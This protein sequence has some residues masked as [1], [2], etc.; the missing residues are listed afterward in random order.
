MHKIIQTLFGLSLLILSSVEVLAVHHATIKNRGGNKIKMGYKNDRWTRHFNNGQQGRHGIE[1]GNRNYDCM[2]LDRER[3]GK[4]GIW[5]HGRDWKRVRRINRLEIL[6]YNGSHD[7]L[8]GYRVQIN[9]PAGK[10]CFDNDDDISCKHA[11]RIHGRQNSVDGQKIG[12]RYFYPLTPGNRQSRQR[13]RVIRWDGSGNVSIRQPHSGNRQTRIGHHRARY[14]NWISTADDLRIDKIMGIKYVL[15]YS[16]WRRKNIKYVLMPNK[17][18]LEIVLNNR[19]RVN[20]KWWDGYCI[21]RRCDRNRFQPLD[22]LSKEHDHSVLKPLVITTYNTNAKVE[23]QNHSGKDL[24]VG[25]RRG[26]MH[27]KDGNH[28]WKIK[29][30]QSRGGFAFNNNTHAIWINP[31]GRTKDGVWLSPK[32]WNDKN[33]SNKRKI[34]KVHIHNG[35]VNGVGYRV[36]LD[37]TGGKYCFREDND[38]N[39]SHV[40]HIHG[41]QPHVDGKPKI[42]DVRGNDQR[43]EFYRLTV[44]SAGG[45]L[46][47]INID[48]DDHVQ[49]NQPY[50]GR[51]GYKLKSRHATRVKFMGNGH[52]IGIHK[53]NGR[54]LLLKY[55]HWHNKNIKHI[56]TMPKSEKLEIITKNKFKLLHVDASKMWEGYCYGKY[57]DTNRFLPLHF[58]DSDR[59]K[60]DRV[61][62]NYHVIMAPSTAHKSV[63]IEPMDKKFKLKQHNLE[64]KELDDGTRNAERSNMVAVKFANAQDDIGIDYHNDGKDGYA[65]RY[66][67]WKDKGVYKIISYNRDRHEIFTKPFTDEMTGMEYRG[68]CVGKKCTN[69]NLVQAKIHPYSNM[70]IRGSKFQEIYPEPIYSGKMVIMENDSKWHPA[71]VGNKNDLKVEIPIYKHKALPFNEDK[72]TIWADLKGDRGF[73]GVYFLHREWSRLHEKLSPR[74]QRILGD[75]LSIRKIRFKGNPSKHNGSP[76]KVE[77][78]TDLGTFCLEHETKKESKCTHSVKVGGRE[79][80]VDGKKI[81]RKHFHKLS[82]Q[83]NLNL[84]DKILVDVGRQHDVRVEFIE[85]GKIEK[86]DKLK[87]GLVTSLNWNKDGDNGDYTGVSFRKGKDLGYVLRHGT[88]NTQTFT[89]PDFNAEGKYQFNDDGSLKTKQQ[90]GIRAK[91]I[92]AHELE[93]FEVHTD[94]FVHSKGGKQF[95]FKGFCIGTKCDRTKYASPKMDFERKKFS[96]SNKKSSKKYFE[97][98]PEVEKMYAGDA[99]RIVNKSAYQL[100]LGHKKDWEEHVHGWGIGA[101]VTTVVV[102]GLVVGTVVTGGALGVIAFKVGTAMALAAGGA[103]TVTALGTTGLVSLGAVATKGIVIAGIAAG[104]AGG[105]GALSATGLGA[106]MTSLR[107]NEK[108]FSFMH[109]SDALWLDRVGDRG[110]PAVYLHPRDWQLHKKDNLA[111]IFGS[112]GVRKLVVADNG[113]DGSPFNLQVET[114]VGIFCLNGDKDDICT[115]RLQVHGKK[116]NVDGVKKGRRKFKK[117][118]PADWTIRDKIL[119]EPISGDDVRVEQSHREIKKVIKNQRVAVNW[120]GNGDDLGV[121]FRRGGGKADDGY[122]LQHSFW[123][124]VRINVITTF[125]KNDKRRMVINTVPFMKDGK[126]WGG[127]CHGNSCDRNFYLSLNVQSERRKVKTSK[128]TYYKV[129]P[130][131]IPAKDKYLDVIKAAQSQEIEA[132][133]TK[134]NTAVGEIETVINSIAYSNVATS[135]RAEIRRLN[136]AKSSINGMES[137]QTLAEEAKRIADDT[138]MKKTNADAKLASIKEQIDQIKALSARAD[139]SKQAEVMAKATTLETNLGSLADEAAATALLASATQRVADE[140]GKLMADLTMQRGM[141]DTE[142]VKIRAA[143]GVMSDQT[144]TTRL[145]GEIT[146]LEE[147]KEALDSVEAVKNLVNNAKEIT[148]QATNYNSIAAKVIKITAEVEKIKA[149]AAVMALKVD[150]DRFMGEATR[151]LEAAKS[152]ELTTAQEMTRDAQAKAMNDEIQRIRQEIS[153]FRASQNNVTD[154][155]QRTEMISSI[156][157]IQ[158]GIGEIS[159][160]T[161]ATAKANQARDLANNAENYEATPED[162]PSP[163][164]TNGDSSSNT[165]ASSDSTL[166]EAIATKFTRVT[167]NC[168][169]NLTQIDG[170]FPHIMAAAEPKLRCGASTFT[171]HDKFKIPTSLMMMDRVNSVKVHR[172][173][174]NLTSLGDFLVLEIDEQDVKFMKTCENVQILQVGD[175]QYMVSGLC[176]IVDKTTGI[177]NIFRSR[178]S[179]FPQ[180]VSLDDLLR[181]RNVNG[182]LILNNNQ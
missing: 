11:I 152:T 124:D 166:S 75:K 167:A 146:R 73:A 140:E 60:I 106:L 105:V 128:K 108:T 33:R 46:R 154:R 120:T 68:F 24:L 170:T 159:T 80:K 132:E 164:E 16:D 172:N 169:G 113:K 155:A 162:T 165:P 182:Q 13:I 129:T 161:D 39:C 134:I 45:T 69:I 70:E 54:S 74:D 84:D 18:K 93:R 15:K 32:D 67:T 14:F 153:R 85:N 179:F 160:V 8:I 30:R 178:R 102:T 12:R 77:M 112:A 34:T 147:Q 92:I 22:V 135:L 50:K 7:N 25:H 107:G 28:A 98:K 181:I 51:H 10:Y 115:H 26:T 118:T 6:R 114:D 119:V 48:N 150:R 121:S 99:I 174:G 123:K 20:N 145:N 87:K 41:K 38:L 100:K 104:S 127:Y 35:G 57:C 95:I 149:A 56:L 151:I 126:M 21:G 88:W 94:T 122:F 97:L 65:I 62:H 158:Q 61:A 4:D 101:G 176:W 130:S 19:F 2:W 133:K 96:Y 47:L 148:I 125:D 36:Q 43:M 139:V 44:D 83:D 163:S 116:D 89:V 109:D 71:S 173:E 82:P 110:L 27:V 17:N 131:F 78:E 111:A 72:E 31:R 59:E 86:I 64:I 42:K 52:N 141:V 177:S 144:E 37:T 103:G 168:R 3:D 66:E 171:F 63:L 180:P 79:D 157:T 143:A 29:K 91:R 23:I 49:L 1:D 5:V 137:A 55:E 156:N 81:D 90:T 58:K 76:L 53:I 117:I 142:I 136:I 138:K 9:T 175:N 40:I